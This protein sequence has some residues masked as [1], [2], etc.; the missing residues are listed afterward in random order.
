MGH[1][2]GEAGDPGKIGETCKM[3]NAPLISLSRQIAL[4]RQ[5][6]V[7]AN[8]LANINTSGF[9]AERILFSQYLMPAASGDNLPNGSQ[10]VAFAQDWGTIQDTTPGAFQQSDNPL[11]VALEGPGFLTVQTPAGLRYTRNGTLHLD[12]QGTLVTSNGDPVMSDAGTVVFQPNE[13]DITIGKDG[14]IS[15]SAGTKGRLQ[16]MEFPNVQA[17]ARQGDTMFSD[18][19]NTA[20]AAAKTF[21]RQGMIEKSNVSGVA[22]MSSMIRVNRAY[23]LMSQIIQRQDD[24]RQSAIRDLGTLS[25]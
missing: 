22:E 4:Q 5:L 3:Q 21:V 9:R 7:V 18:P 15:S 17:L 13:T 8:N 24:L 11:D 10:S 6:D 23:E 20:I 16:V 25:A 19:G 2:L 12:A 14:S 1:R